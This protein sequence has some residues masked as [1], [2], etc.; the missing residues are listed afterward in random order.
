MR[1]RAHAVV[2]VT[3]REVGSLGDYGRTLARHLP[4]AQLELDARGT[5]M[6]TFD[7]RPVGRNPFPRVHA[8]EHQD[9]VGRVGRSRPDPQQARRRPSWVACGGVEISVVAG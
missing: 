3:T 5:S 7:A 9:A 1:G 4:V 6:E 2:V 8:A